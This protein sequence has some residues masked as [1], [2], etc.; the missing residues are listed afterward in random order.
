MRAS[1]RDV[2]QS[3][4][5]DPLLKEALSELMVFTTEVVGSDGARARLRH[6][7]NGFGLAFG[8]SSYLPNISH[9][10]FSFRIVIK[11]LIKF[12]PASS[13]V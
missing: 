7:Q 6:E 9:R 13:T 3:P 12:R 2:L 10:Q 11:H 1:V 4:D 5:C 8:P